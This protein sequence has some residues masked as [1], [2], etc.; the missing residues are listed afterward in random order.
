MAVNK[1][2]KSLGLTTS[3]GE[4]AATPST[5]AHRQA[6]TL[7]DKRGRGRGVA[8]PRM[9]GGFAALLAV[10][11]VARMADAAPSYVQSTYTVPQ[12]PQATVTVPFTA[13]QA[14]GDLNVVIVGWYDTTS[15]VVSV[16]DS[17]GHAYVRAVGPTTEAAAGTQSIY[18]AA[19]IG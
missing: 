8:P 7:S 3:P 1:K 14:A 18:Y 4:S 2:N 12:A 5:L 10:L 17:R 9:A 16:T 6:W 19:G 11:S 15:S 13:A